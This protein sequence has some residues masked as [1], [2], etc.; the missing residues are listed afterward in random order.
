MK[1][2]QK[3]KDGEARKERQIR[4]LAGEIADASQLDIMLLDAQPDM[5]RAVFEHLRPYLRF[6]VTAEQLPCLRLHLQNEA[7]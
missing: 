7:R 2:K 5:R 3:R 4:A 1:L 6:P